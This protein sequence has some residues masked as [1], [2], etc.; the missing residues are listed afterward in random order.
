MKIPSDELE[1]VQF[2]KRTW[3]NL[4]NILAL[5]S[6]MIGFI[7]VAWWLFFGTPISWT[8][9]NIDHA[10]AN[11]QSSRRGDTNSVI[12][13]GQLP[14]AVRKRTFS[15]VKDCTLFRITLGMT[16]DEVKYF[17]GTSGY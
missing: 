14:C 9:G 15:S 12:M 10:N 3:R 13:T 11:T 8:F 6:V 1:R 2:W 7:T 16:V 17:I 5:T 4:W